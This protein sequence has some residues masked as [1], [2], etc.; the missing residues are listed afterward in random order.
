MKNFNMCFKIVNC[1]YEMKYKFVVFVC[2]VILLRKVLKN[3]EKL[4]WS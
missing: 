3:L 4:V 1:V 2:L